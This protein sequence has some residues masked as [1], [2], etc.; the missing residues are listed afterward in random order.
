M[1]HLLDTNSCIVFLRQGT[2]SILAKRLAAAKPGSVVLC[3]IV[4]AEL[5]Y[6]ARRSNQTTKNL[7]GVNAFCEA[8]VSLPFDDSAADQYG[9]IRDHLVAQ[10]MPIGPNDLLIASIAA[11]NRLALVT[12]NVAEFRRVPGLVVE[13]WQVE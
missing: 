5:F 11:A 4:V 8:F 3:S 10:G 6:G 2:S 13:D 1:T 7:A 12:H 9:L